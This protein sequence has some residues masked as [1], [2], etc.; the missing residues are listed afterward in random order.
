MKLFLIL[1]ALTALAFGA[2][3]SVDRADAAIHEIV[4][5]YCSGGGVG[6]ISDDGFLEAPGISDPTES[7]F[8]KPVFASGATTAPDADGIVHISG[9]PNA[10]FPEGTEVV[11]LIP[12]PPTSLL[13]VSEA[14]HPSAEHC[15]GADG[16]P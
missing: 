11:D 8:A 9:K 3:V 4:A 7:N 5:A 2:F 15:P 13:Q 6:V 16:L 1:S 12:P 10:K 14:D